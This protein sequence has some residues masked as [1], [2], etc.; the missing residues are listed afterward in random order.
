[1]GVYLHGQNE[2]FGASRF[3]S[4][5]FFEGSISFVYQPLKMQ[6]AGKISALRPPKFMPLVT[7]STTFPI[8]QLCPTRRDVYAKREL[9]RFGQFSS[10]AARIGARNRF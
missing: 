4:G 3:W 6:S 7:L 2:G 10:A 9:M 5:P 8:N 1:M